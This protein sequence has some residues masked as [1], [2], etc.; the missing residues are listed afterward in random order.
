MEKYSQWRDPGT[1]IQPFLPPAPVRSGRRVGQAVL[2]SLL[3]YLLGPLIALVR[4]VALFPVIGLTGCV[5]LLCILLYVGAIQRL[6]RAL[7][8]RP[9]GRLLFILLGFYRL[10]HTITSL[11]RGRAIRQPLDTTSTHKP[12][13]SGDLILANHVSYLDVLYLYYFYG[14]IFVRQDVISRPNGEPRFYRVEFW[15]ALTRCYEAGEL[16]SAAHLTRLN[17][18]QITKEARRTRT[19]PVVLF[20]EGTTSNG[21]ALLSSLGPF[22]AVQDVDPDTSL[23]LLLF[24]YPLRYPSPVFPVGNMFG[25]WLSLCCQPFNSMQVLELDLRETPQMPHAIPASSTNG[26]NT[27]A[28]QDLNHQIIQS[29]ANMGRL[30]TTKLGIREKQAFLQYYFKRGQK[31]KH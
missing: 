18:A 30:R 31:P 23:H 5:E 9:L 28:F 22:T 20:V 15:H 10:P 3:T 25:H 29:I 1:G 11:K 21:R 6:V 2:E 14:P 24:Q 12:V 7:L 16:N 26:L 17:L 19:G 4:L 27:P 13:V 8:L